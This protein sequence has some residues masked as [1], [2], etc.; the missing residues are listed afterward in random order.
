AIFSAAASSSATGEAGSLDANPTT[1]PAGVI[2][3]QIHWSADGEFSLTLA[4]EAPVTSSSTG[5]R[6]YAFNT[7]MSLCCSALADTF[8]SCGSKFRLLANAI[9][10]SMALSRLML[11][12]RFRLG[13]I[14]ASE[15]LPTYASGD[16][17]R[18]AIHAARPERVKDRFM[19]FGRVY[20][21]RVLHAPR[22]AT[23]KRFSGR[24]DTFASYEK[25]SHLQ[26]PRG[27]SCHS[28][29]GNPVRGSRQRSQLCSSGDRG[30]RDCPRLVLRDFR[31]RAGAG[32]HCGIAASLP[33]EPW[34]HHG[35]LHAR[36]RFSSPGIPLL[37]GGWPGLRDPA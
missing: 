9:A 10:I 29:S 11:M 6:S 25:I 5:C 15:K 24:L 18:I 30:V 8:Q 23:V 28:R 27:D 35:H 7:A 13:R 3:T 37:H 17:I 32:E 31:L 16:R 12:G 19:Q 22:G 2:T 14:L 4:R 1:R 21:I 26:S 33:H 34:R 20:R 36:Q